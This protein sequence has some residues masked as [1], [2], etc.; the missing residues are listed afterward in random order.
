[1]N[2]PKCDRELVQ[3]ARFCG[4]CGERLVI[5]CP[6]CEVLNPPDG[7]F[8]YNCGGSLTQAERGA[9]SPEL[10]SGGAEQRQAVSAQ[11]TRCETVN[12]P[13]A[14]Y[15]YKCGLPLEEGQPQ[16]VRQS[17][18][19]PVPSIP[20]APEPGEQTYPL[21]PYRPL[22]R[23]AG[24]TIGLLVTQCI[25]LGLL[26]L[27]ELALFGVTQE[28][29]AGELRDVTRL[30]DGR[31][32][33]NV[34]LA[35]LFLA[36]IPTVVLFLMWMDRASQNLQALGA[37]GQLFSSRWVVGG[38][39][40]PFAHFIVPY[41]VMASL[42]RASDPELLGEPFDWKR[43]RV[44]VLLRLWWVC[45]L[46]SSLVGL[47]A[48]GSPFFP[49]STTWLSSLFADWLVGFADEPSSDELLWEIVASALS[50]CAGVLA[51]LIVRR[52]TSRQEE[53]HQ[54]M[55]A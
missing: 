55:I 3:Y 54:R 29:E 31:T 47:I 5:T 9:K 4:Y 8:C 38:W 50:I 12:E 19:A 22:G 1:M 46:S 7:R 41:K 48:G 36:F 52:I 33:W 18:D 32:G 40:V 49:H 6:Q 10:A 16:M 15:C 28:Y 23:R 20:A 51:I 2:C 35:L 26:M 53:K 17:R 11:C 42:W 21:P 39:F 34:A 37:R 14:K 25:G 45:W 44:P 30:T 13:A 27:F 24:W 43:G